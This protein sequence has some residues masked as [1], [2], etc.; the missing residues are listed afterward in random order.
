MAK[1]I[2]IIEDE[3]QLRE[4]YIQKISQT[5]FEVISA[6]DGEEGFRLAKQEKPDL[7]L[8]D[9]L[10]PKNNGIYFLKKLREAPETSTIRVVAFSNFDDPQMKG[11]AMGLGVLDYLIKTNY[12][13]RQIVE[14][15]KGYLR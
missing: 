14:K 2:L 7:I 9:I 1:K 5:G 8:L 13:P 12:T 6:T 15:I 4:I 10:L 3:K 11:K